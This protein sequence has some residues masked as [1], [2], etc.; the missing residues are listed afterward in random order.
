M[1]VQASQ[2]QGPVLILRLLLSAFLRSAHL[3]D[4]RILSI[5]G[6]ATVFWSELIRA[7]AFRDG[8]ARLLSA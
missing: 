7:C 4:L 6:Q 1:L 8:S 2:K 3:T 5:G